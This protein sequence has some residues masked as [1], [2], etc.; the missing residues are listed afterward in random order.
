MYSGR[1]T[2]ELSAERR[3]QA[4]FSLCVQY[5]CIVRNVVL[6]LLSAFLGGA[7]GKLGGRGISL[8]GLIS[9]GNIL[10]YFQS[11]DMNKRMIIMMTR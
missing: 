7:G 9:D 5:F 4:E 10:L 8:F 11:F 3:T 2:G 6:L 1:T